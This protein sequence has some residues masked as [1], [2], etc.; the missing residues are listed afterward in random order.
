MAR[1]NILWL[2]TDEQRTDS[3]GACCSPWART[4]NLDRLAEKGTLF[5][6]AYTPSPVCVPARAALLT[7]RACSPLGL[8]NNHQPLPDPSAVFLTDRFRDAGYQTASFGK[9]HYNSA[10]PAFETQVQCVLGDRVG[11]TE[12]PEDLDAREHG[13]VQYPGSK[14]YRGFKWL[15]GGRYPG[16]VDDLPE[17]RVVGES[18]DWLS[19][20]DRSRPFF[21][22]LSFNA[23]H[24]PV[25]PPAPWDTLIDPTDVHLPV[26]DLDSMAGAPGPVGEYLIER[27]GA[28][29]LTREDIARARQ[30]YYGLVAC[31]DALFGRV[32]EAMRIAGEL[33]NT[34]IAFVSDHGAHLADHGFFQKCSFFDAA[35]RV[36][37]ILKLPGQTRGRVVRTPVSTGTLLPT[38]LDLAGL[39]VPRGTD[40]RSLA[41]CLSAGGEPDPEP[42]VSEIDH[43]LHG[44]RT[45]ERYAMVRIGRW[46]LWV[47]RDPGATG[48]VD[49]DGLGLYDLES[50]PGE[51]VNRAADPAC[52]PVIDD[53]CGQLDGWD[54]E[55]ASGQTRREADS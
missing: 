15:L 4:P 18:L 34:I 40:Y 54:A 50:D 20:R 30:C 53:L 38:L 46:K 45:G 3:I 21:L 9:H 48:P 13:V 25:V 23:P 39:D 2:M 49:P 47:Y 27:S 11:Y 52:L 44:Y 37:F 41:P 28:H 17:A 8:Y 43:G 33:D 6:D 35:A 1:P 51:R 24:T 55:R 32:L 36:P 7:G 29:R 16:S 19:R 12:F 26:D 22:R 31:A 14:R 10:R 5:T 42:V